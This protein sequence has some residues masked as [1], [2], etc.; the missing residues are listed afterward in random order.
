MAKSKLNL[1]SV[2]KFRAF[3]GGAWHEFEVE[4]CGQSLAQEIGHKAMRTKTGKTKMY[5]GAVTVKHC[6]R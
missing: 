2:G 4:I 1:C 5:G 3:I 6:G